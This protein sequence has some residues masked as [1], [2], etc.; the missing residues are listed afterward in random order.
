MAERLLC[1]LASLNFD[2]IFLALF[3][4]LTR[5]EKVAR[6]ANKTSDPRQQLYLSP[7]GLPDLYT[8]K[9]AFE[10]L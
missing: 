1:L 7:D 5:R 4:R 8:V 9:A 6:G 2:D 3:E 10:F